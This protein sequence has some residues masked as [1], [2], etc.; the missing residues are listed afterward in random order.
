MKKE[1][2]ITELYRRTRVSVDEDDPVLIILALAEIIL[3]SQSDVT[4]ERVSLIANGFERSAEKTSNSIVEVLNKSAGIL[5]GLLV[6]IEASKTNLSIPEY[7]EV[8]HPKTKE[9]KDD[10][11]F[12]ERFTKLAL[13]CAI[14]SMGALFAFLVSGFMWVFFR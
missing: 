14:F 6:Q 10:E 2:V 11:S 3:E 9:E 13:T 1:E 12:K 7:L 5:Q 8:K 4:A